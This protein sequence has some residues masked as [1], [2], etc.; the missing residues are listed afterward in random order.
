[1]KH[2]LPEEDEIQS[3]SKLDKMVTTFSSYSLPSTAMSVSLY[4][5]S[6]DNPDKRPINH[7]VMLEIYIEIL[8]QKLTKDNIYRDRFD[9]TNKV[10]LL[11]RIA[12]KIDSSSAD[13]F[14]IPMSEF[15]RIIEEYFKDLVA[16][17]FIEPTRISEYFIERKIFTK[18]QGD[19][20]RFTY[21]CYYH[22]FLAKRMEYNPKFREYVLEESRYHKYFREIDYYTALVRSD[23]ETFKLIARRFQETF[24]P[25]DFIL[26]KLDVD[27]YFTPLSPSDVY[28]SEA[29]KI[30]IDKVKRE[31]PSTSMLE[32]YYDNRLKSINDPSKIIKVEGKIS[33]DLLMV[34]MA[35][36][37]RNS[38]GIEDRK[39]KRE[40]YND[41][42]KYN[43]VYMIL[44]KEEIIRYVKQFETLP[45]SIPSEI[46]LDYLLKN[47][48]L[49]VQQALNRNAASP[50]LSSIILDKIKLDKQKKSQTKSDIESF[51]SVALYADIQ[52]QDFDREI[53]YLVKRVK[54]NPTQDYLYHKLLDYYYR[55]TRPASS[56]E[57][58]YLNL[59][60]DLR[61]RSM[62]LPKSLKSKVQKAIADGKKLFLDSSDRLSKN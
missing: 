47:I 32:K 41:L 39:L 44:Y 24:K 37:L 1:M 31:R 3:E 42:I 20:I 51:L 9:F 18:K 40:L 58:M 15:I 57:E 2:W 54:N 48:P 13:N 12:E 46:R 45:P 55:R 23:I 22:F 8:L 25:T 27:F 43:I 11:A 62:K 16:F 50:K 38:E 17:D 30:D 19:K 56:N 33:L 26:E 35:N 61:L 60:A 5:W 53:K 10:Q 49:F 34:I 21:S 29:K 28:D 6:L 59:L 14:T 7:A 36:V 4:L 52:G